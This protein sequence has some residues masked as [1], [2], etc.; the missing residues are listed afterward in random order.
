MERERKP[1]SR[2]RGRATK[3]ATCGGK[4]RPIR[5]HFGHSE[6]CSKRCLDRFLAKRTDHPTSL[7]AWINEV[8]TTKG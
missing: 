8:R 4:F 6:C 7:K 5:Y 1:R 3:C 2:P